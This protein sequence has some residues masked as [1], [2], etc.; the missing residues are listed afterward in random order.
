M[1]EKSSYRASTIGPPLVFAARP[2]AAGRGWAMAGAVCAAAAL[3]ATGCDRDSRAAGHPEGGASAAPAAKPD[4]LA[5]LNPPAPAAIH[6][7]CAH[8]V[9]GHDFFV[10]APPAADCAVGQPCKLALTL[11]A[12]GD[13]HINDDYPYKFRADD[14]PGVEFLGTDGGGKNVFSK[15]ARNWTKNDEKTGTMAVVFRPLEKGSKGIGGLFK[16]SVCSSQNC[17]LEQPQIN[18]TVAVR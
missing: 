12:A 3:W 7:G 4:P 2:G 14:A 16:L 13:Y 10:D 5:P 17:R 9:C 15:V 6:S 18:A 11:V 1:N 8:A